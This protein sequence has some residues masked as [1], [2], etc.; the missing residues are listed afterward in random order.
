M[1]RARPRAPARLAHADRLAADLADLAL[2]R[3]RLGGEGAAA[4]DRAR[5]DL[6]AVFLRIGRR[7]ARQRLLAPSRFS[8]LRHGAIPAP[9]AS[10]T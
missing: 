10:G 9:S 3:D 4:V 6:D 2:G 7:P 5:P 8:R 1:I